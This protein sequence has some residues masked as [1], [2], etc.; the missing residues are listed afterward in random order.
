MDP[1]NF[2]ASTHSNIDLAINIDSCKIESTALSITHETQEGCGTLLVR[3]GW[4]ELSCSYIVV[5]SNSRA[6][7][8]Q[9][10]QKQDQILVG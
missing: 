1:I 2:I 7:S 5:N 6:Q 8:T 9:L 3:H 4:Y 10:P